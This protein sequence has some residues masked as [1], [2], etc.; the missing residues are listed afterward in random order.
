MVLS[1]RY[2]FRAPIIHHKVL[3]IKDS[4]FMKHTFFFTSL[5]RS[6]LP[7]VAPFSASTRICRFFKIGPQP[8]EYTAPQGPRLIVKEKTFL[9]RDRQVEAPTQL[10]AGAFENL[11]WKDST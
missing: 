8:C 7:A 3:K 10:R 6:V 2:S 9:S 4:R 1:N 5:A 11:K